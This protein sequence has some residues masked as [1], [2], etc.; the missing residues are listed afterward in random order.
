MCCVLLFCSLCCHVCVWQ[1]GAQTWFA[2]LKPV[3]MPL[4]WVDGGG[5]VADDQAAI[6]KNSVRL[7]VFLSR[8]FLAFVFVLVAF[9]CG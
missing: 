3:Y 1:V 8:R 4:S 7:A 2:N 9:G 6:F 5:N